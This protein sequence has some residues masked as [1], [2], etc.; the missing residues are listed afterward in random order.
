MRELGIALP[1]HATALGKALLAFHPSENAMLPDNEPL[2]RLTGRT[3]STREALDA[4]LDRTRAD[5]MGY[6]VDEVVLGESEVAAAIF[7]AHGV[8]VGAVGVVLPTP[9]IAHDAQGAADNPMSVF[10]TVTVSAVR[11]SAIGISRSMGAM[12]WPMG[13]NDTRQ[14][15]RGRR[16]DKTPGRAMDGSAP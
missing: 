12:S 11:E 7:D 3:L 1:A 15:G 9:E 6:E 13:Q 4:E 14:S 8:A 2:R 16:S 5:G 10:G